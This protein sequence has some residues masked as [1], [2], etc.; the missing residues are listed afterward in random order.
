MQTRSNRQLLK[1]SSTS[2]PW[3]VFGES[4]IPEDTSRGALKSSFWRSIGNTLVINLSHE[5]LDENWEE[6]NGTIIPKEI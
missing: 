6:F 2:Q 5:K 4:L 3:E 1:T